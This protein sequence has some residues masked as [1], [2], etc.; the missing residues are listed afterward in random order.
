LSAVLT[1]AA[2]TSPPWRQSLAVLGVLL[3][4]LTLLY[5]DTARAMEGIWSRSETFAHAYLVAPISLWLVWRLRHRVAAMVP[6]PQPWVLLPMLLAA[7]AWFVGDLAGVN[8]LTQ[9]MFVALLVLAVPAVLGLAVARELAFPLVYLFFM[10]PFGEFLLPVLMERTAD[11]TVLAVALSGVPVYREGLNFVIPSGT[12][13]VVEACSGVRYLI[14]SFMVGSLFAYL[15]YT[16]TKRRLIFCAVSLALPV[17]A[18]WLRA[19]FIVMLGHLSGNKLAVGVDHLIYGWAFFGVVITALFLIGA[20]WTEPP[21]SVLPAAAGQGPLPPPGRVPAWLMAVLALALVAWPQALLRQMSQ[22]TTTA[23]APVLTLPALAGTQAPGADLPEF[24][25]VFQGPSA[26]AR[27]SYG[28]GARDVSVHVA[29]FRGQRY[30]RKLVTSENMLVKPGDSR[31]NAT[32]RGGTVLDVDG[33][34]IALRTAEVLGAG[35]LGHGGR[36]R[37]E[38]RQVYWVDGRFTAS[39]HWAVAYGVWSRM[40]GLGDDG[41]MLTIFTEGGADEGTQEL[42]D[43]FIRTHLGDLQ[44]QLSATRAAR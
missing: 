7:S 19:Y 23:A 6:S 29:Y 16:S 28:V 34:P 18:N 42:L 8:A 9:A 2:A 3:L 40:A 17:V 12:W 33:Q 35:T 31:W 43:G 22:E 20:R 15:N 24:E 14:A 11:F 32:R 21:A 39:D 25:P 27:R 30:G 37:L 41:A 38:V 13:S 1:P 44:R 26:V 10:V 4:A 36:E 5:L